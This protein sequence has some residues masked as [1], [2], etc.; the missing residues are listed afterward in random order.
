MAQL[1]STVN[2]K[3]GSGSPMSGMLMGMMPLIRSKLAEV[4]EKSLSTLANVMAQAFE[5][6]SDPAVTEKE[7]E[8]WLKFD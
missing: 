6:V 1:I 4:D 5:K 8:E 7:F 3:M 2:T